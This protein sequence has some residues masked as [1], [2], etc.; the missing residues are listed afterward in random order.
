VNFDRY[1][2]NFFDDLCTEISP[3]TKWAP[4]DASV[5]FRDKDLRLMENWKTHIDQA[6]QSSAVL[7]CITSPAYLNSKF[8][9]KEYYVFDQRRR[10]GLPSTKEPP[11][12]ILPVIW[13]PV[14]EGLPGYLDEVQQVPSKVSTAYRDNGLRYLARF[15]GSAYEQC[16]TAFAQ[17]I[18]RAWREHRN[19]RPL[20]GSRD[21]SDIPDMFADSEWEEAAGPNG[22]LS[23]PEVAN[24]VFASALKN[25]IPHPEGRYGSHGSE[26]RPYLPPDATTVL[27]HARS[28][29]RKQSLKFREIPISTD[30]DDELGS[31]KRRKNLSVVIADPKALHL[32][33]CQPIGVL[34]KHWWE[35]SA[36]ILPSEDEQTCQNGL[37]A[38]FP[39]LS[40][41]KTPN[42]RGPVRTSKEL[43]LTLDLTLTELRA[44]VTRVETSKKKK[45][46]EAP[47]MLTGTTESV[48]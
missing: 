38:T 33:S 11:P 7:V 34:E 23:G 4:E 44:A 32:K 20:S 42:V 10:Q 41:L 5:S 12:V 39:L 30:M 36:L 3:W 15:D 47:P 27:E 8:C 35:G 22:W 45:T 1:L 26:W 37:N 19:I 29:T 40:Q 9:G 14:V 24:F 6:L 48:G 16:V 28:A 46:D 31:V 25:E 18:V 43:E 2:A 21:F 17:A 13:A